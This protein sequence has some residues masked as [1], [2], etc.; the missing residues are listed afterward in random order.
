MIDKAVHKKDGWHYY[1][2]GKE[3]SQEE[4]EAVYPPLNPTGK[5]GMFMTPSTCSWPY[6]SLSVGCH[7]IDREKFMA[8]AK[9]EGVPT[10]YTPDG[11]AVFTSREHQRRFARAFGLRNDDENWS[12]G[13]DKRPP[14]PPKK[15]P[16]MGKPN[17]VQSNEPPQMRTATKD[18]DRPR[19]RKS[20]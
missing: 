10:D 18:A 8:A 15:R 5:I 3:V 11:H 6:T 14:R 19:R 7:P 12:G 4:F 16:K 1:I 9:A 20:R 2:A 13:G 17:Q